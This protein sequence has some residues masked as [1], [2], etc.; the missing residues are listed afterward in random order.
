MHNSRSDCPRSYHDIN[1]QC[2][3]ICWTRT[4]TTIVNHS[5]HRTHLYVM[6]KSRKV[7]D[8]SKFRAS[9]CQRWVDTCKAIALTYDWL[10]VMLKF[11]IR[12]CELTETMNVPPYMAL[13]DPDLQNSPATAAVVEQRFFG[14]F[15]DK[16]IRFSWVEWPH[17]FWQLFHKIL[18]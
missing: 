2:N 5:M 15:T 9:K 8:V 14:R 3:W 12:F 11:H 6:E 7:C 4:K 16:H 18:F 1:A 17:F 10:C 13:Q